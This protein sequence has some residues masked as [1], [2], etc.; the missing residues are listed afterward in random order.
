MKQHPCKP[1]PI[2]TQLISVVT[3]VLVAGPTE[4]FLLGELEFLS[5]C[6]LEPVQV[7]RRFDRRN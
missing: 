5:K 2:Q 1:V 6:F 3:V 7:V 4:D